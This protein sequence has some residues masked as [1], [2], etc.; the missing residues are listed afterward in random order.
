MCVPVMS[1][2]SPTNNVL[3]QITVPKRTGRKR[4]RGS[5]DPYTDEN[6][7]AAPADERTSS[8]T[9]PSKIR[10]QSRM[11]KPAELLRTL[12]DNVG[13]YKVE[14]VGQVN[15]THRFRGMA[16]ID[17]YLDTCS[18]FNR[19]GRFPSVDKSFQLHAKIPEQPSWG[20]Q[21]VIAPCRFRT[22]Y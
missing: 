6:G 13:R 22:C 7:F 4:K 17:L 5:Q 20:Q 12:K 2:N 18:Y 1:H 21:S 14:A 15:Q 19:S 9:Q 10:S 8:V 3:L 11:D 16:L